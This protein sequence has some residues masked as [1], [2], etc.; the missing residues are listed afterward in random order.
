[1][2][3]IGKEKKLP[4]MSKLLEGIARVENQANI[5]VRD[6]LKFS[7]LNI[8]YFKDL[9]G[10]DCIGESKDNKLHGRGIRIGKDGTF[11]I[12][13]YENNWFTT[14]NFIYVRSNESV[15]VGEW[16]TDN[17]E[18]KRRYTQYKKDGT[19]TKFNPWPLII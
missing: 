1:M 14:G 11:Y 13:H 8:K 17:G 7:N 15:D 6:Y 9:E 19:I 4:H 3:Q 5:S 16:C 10:D 18:K 12:Q 2:I